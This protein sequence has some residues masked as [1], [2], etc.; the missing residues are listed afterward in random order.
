MTGGYLTP[1][2]A[3]HYLAELLGT[4]F[5]DEQRAVITAPLGPQLVIAGAGSGKTTVVAARVVHA[6]AFHGVA[7]SAVLGLTF[8]NKAASELGERVRRALGRLA[9]ARALEAPSAEAMLA[10]DVPTVS[11][12]HAYAAQIVADNA[13]RIGREPQNR[14]LTEAARWQVAMRVARTARGAFEFLRWTTPFVAQFVLDLDAEMSEH[15]VGIDDVRGANARIRACSA[16]RT[17]IGLPPISA[18]GL[19][20]KRVLA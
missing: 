5:S 14:L 6:V 4:P 11:T 12:Y 1:D 18:S 10:D 2:A 8:T 17:I 15:L 7:P 3:G 19:P 16:T 9:A 20:G 13:L